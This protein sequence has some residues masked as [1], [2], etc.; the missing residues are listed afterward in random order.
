MS[1]RPTEHEV[2]MRAVDL[3]AQRSTCSRA[4]VGAVAARDGRIIATG[5][6]GA[7]SHMA[8]CEHEALSV[9]PCKIAVHAEANVVAFAA[10]YGTALEG[11]TLYV[12]MEPCIQCAK[13]LINAGIKRV[14]FRGRYGGERG[15]M[16]L[17]ISAGLIVI[18]D[19]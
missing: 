6:N 13:L 7:P 17:L 18:Y 15:G 8:H 9:E 16:P 11:A 19:D 5:Y 2:L 3:W 4:S 14:H 1:P 10:R 12:T